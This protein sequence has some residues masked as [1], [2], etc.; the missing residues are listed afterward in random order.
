MEKG[1]TGKRDYK[2][3]SGNLGGGITIFTISIMMMV[4]QA[5]RQVKTHT[6][7]IYIYIYSFGVFFF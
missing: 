5:Y 4:S 1:R 3:A 2:G 7:H 6:L